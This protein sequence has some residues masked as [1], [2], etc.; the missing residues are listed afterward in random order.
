MA[1]RKRFFVVPS[2]PMWQVKY[3]AEVLSTHST[4]E[5][6]VAAGQGIAKANQPSQLIVLRKDGT[7]EYEY[8]Y[9]ADPYPPVG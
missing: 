1:T 7:I 3:N 2:G 6:A 8:T 5:Q 9:G 4:K